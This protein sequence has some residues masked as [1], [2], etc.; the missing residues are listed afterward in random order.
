MK[1]L[2]LAGTFRT[3]TLA[4]ARADQLSAS[5]FVCV[6][7]GSLSWETCFK[8]LNASTDLFRFAMR[9]A[10]ADILSKSGAGEVGS[11]DVNHTIFAYYR[12]AEG[13][14]ASALEAMLDELL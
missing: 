2:E 14:L 4:P 11:S 7:A 10:A 8:K 3:L 13:N 6:E 12:R 5:G 1:T 9:R